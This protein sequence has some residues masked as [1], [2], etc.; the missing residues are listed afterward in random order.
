MNKEHLLLGLGWLLFCALHSILASVTVKQTAQRSFGKSYKHYRLFYTLFAF[1]TLGIVLYHLIFLKSPYLFEAG[2]VSYVI[3]GI[4]TAAGLVIMAICIKKYFMSL[5][6]LKSLFQE[7]PTNELMIQGIH[8]YVRHPLYLGTFIFIWGLLV[9]FP[10]LSGLISNIFITGYTLIGIELEE[11]KLIAEFGND[12]KTY[13]KTV[14]KL[15]PL[16]RLKQS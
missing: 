12:Y 1:L 3:G 11:R 16:R 6:G 10:T 15:L 2:T 8:R 5:S 7:H 14:P 4:I 13:Q 9:L